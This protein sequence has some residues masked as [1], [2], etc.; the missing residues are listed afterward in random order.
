MVTIDSYIKTFSDYYFLHQC[1]SYILRWTYIFDL[2]SYILCR[3]TVFYVLLMSKRFYDVLI[4][5]ALY[6]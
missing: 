5:T 3:Y 6:R 1:H 2:V 4:L